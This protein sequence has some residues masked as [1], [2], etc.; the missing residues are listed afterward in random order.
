MWEVSR[1]TPRACTEQGLD[2]TME[3]IPYVDP[4]CGGHVADVPCTSLSLQGPS[5]GFLFL[6]RAWTMIDVPGESWGNPLTNTHISCRSHSNERH[7]PLNMSG[8]LAGVEVELG[9]THSEALSSLS[10]GGDKERLF[11]SLL[12]R[13]IFCKG[14]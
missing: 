9:S 8:I 4:I 7:I 6:R 11:I 5:S 14:P 2:M 10:D 12:Q 1:C 13:G 3:Y